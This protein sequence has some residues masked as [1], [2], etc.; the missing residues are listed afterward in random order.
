MGTEPCGASQATRPAVSAGMRGRLREGATG[1]S[2]EKGLRKSAASGGKA[3]DYM[4]RPALA[5]LGWTLPGGSRY[6][7]AA[8]KASSQEQSA[9]SGRTAQQDCDKKTATRR[10]SKITQQVSSKPSR[11]ARRPPP[12][13]A[14][15]RSRPMPLAIPSRARSSGDRVLASEAKGRRFDSC[16]ARHFRI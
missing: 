10:R 13:L 8:D 9:A 11:K 6:P 2:R 12:C 16:R 14:A 3:G 7:R 1:R 15:A 5:A 4:R